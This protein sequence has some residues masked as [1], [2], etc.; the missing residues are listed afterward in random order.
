MAAFAT[1]PANESEWISGIRS[2]RP[3]TDGP[4]DVGTRVQRVAGFLGRR[5]DYILE[6][7]TYE[8]DRLVVMDSV[9]NPFP[10]RVTYAFAD[11]PGST[12]V[13]LRVQ[14]GAGGLFRL[15]G[16]LLAAQVRRNLHADLRNLKRLTESATLVE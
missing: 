4:L 16:P 12:L 6:V 3:L 14:G 8:S 1:N 9:V 7:T 13:R 5:I 10:I 11:A 2:S 15:A